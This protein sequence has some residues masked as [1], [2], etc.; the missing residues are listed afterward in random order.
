VP[1]TSPLSTSF[2]TLSGRFISLYRQFSHPVFAALEPFLI[3]YLLL[4]YL[5][6]LPFTP[7]SDTFRTDFHSL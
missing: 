7:L 1:L 2:V 5:F 4:P 6:L 3:V